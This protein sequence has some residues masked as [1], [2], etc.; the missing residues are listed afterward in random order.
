AMAAA[1]ALPTLAMAKSDSQVYIAD[2][3]P[4]NAEATDLQTN[5]EAEITVDGDEVTI[6]IDIR[7]TAPDMVHWQHFHGFEDGS[8]ANCPAPSLD[9]NDDGYVDLIETHP[10]S[11]VTM[12]PFDEDPAAMDV[13]DGVYPTASEEGDYSYEQTVSLEA[14]QAAYGEAFDG[15]DLDLRKRV[16]YI[17]GVP[18]DTDLP[19][20]VESLGP[21]PAQVTLP[22]AGGAIRPAE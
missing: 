1:M 7:D 2:I 12:V 15:Q 14:L 17:H 8:E 5:G 9:E 4:M 6:R 11:G 16:I 13:A 18:E 20:S 22:I 3:Q 19:D 21:I 10:A